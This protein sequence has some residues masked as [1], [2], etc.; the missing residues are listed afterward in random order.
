MGAK[1]VLALWAF[2]GVKVGTAQEALA[3]N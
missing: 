2:V 1:R 3:S